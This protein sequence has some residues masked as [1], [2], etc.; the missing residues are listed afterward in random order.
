MLNYLSFNKKQLYFA[1]QATSM[2]HKQA[3]TPD[4]TEGSRIESKP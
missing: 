1:S 4:E 2:R 3:G